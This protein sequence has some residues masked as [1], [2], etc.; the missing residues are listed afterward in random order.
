[1]IFRGKISDKIPFNLYLNVILSLIC[2]FI[3]QL[4]KRVQYHDHLRPV[5]LPTAATNLK[6]GTR[7]I[8]IGWGKKNDTD[9]K[10][11]I[12]YLYYSY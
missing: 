8:V 4:E 10:Y 5:C 6:T 2:Y 11:F 7:C 1:M 9:C 12:L 3:L